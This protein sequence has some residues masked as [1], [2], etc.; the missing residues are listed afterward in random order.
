MIRRCGRRRS[1][2]RMTLLLEGGAL[3]GKGEGG[4]GEGEGREGF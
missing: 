3:S 1:V 4:E 2:G